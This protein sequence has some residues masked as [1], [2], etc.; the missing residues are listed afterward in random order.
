VAVLQEQ[1]AVML[2]RK[3]APPAERPMQ[4]SQPATSPANLPISR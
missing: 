2:S 3:S 4:A 1:G